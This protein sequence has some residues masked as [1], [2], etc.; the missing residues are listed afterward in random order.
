VSNIRSVCVAA[1][2]AAI[3]APNVDPELRRSL[4]THERV[5]LFI[6]NLTR[7]FTQAERNGV[8]VSRAMIEA[9]THDMTQIFIGAV[10]RSAEEKLLSPLAIALKNA[11]TARAERLKKQIDALTQG[12][13]E[14]VKTDEKGNETSVSQVTVEGF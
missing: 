14:H 6:D 11:E 2:R 12:E 8:K 10:I 9:G 3:N 1:Y 7:E 4:R 5:P 13:I